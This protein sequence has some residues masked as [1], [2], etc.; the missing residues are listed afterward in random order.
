MFLTRLR[1]IWRISLFL[2][3][4]FVVLR[5]LFLIAFIPQFIS[6]PLPAIFQALFIG[7]RLD[8][9]LVVLIVLPFFLISSL[10]GLGF[11]P[12]RPKQTRF[13]RGYF[14]SIWMLMLFVYM[15][16]FGFYDYLLVR[17]DASMLAFAQSPITSLLMVWESYPLIAGMVFF[18]AVGYGSKRLFVRLMQPVTR[19]KHPGWLMRILYGFIAFI[20]MGALAYGSWSRYPLRWSDAFFSTHQP[21]NQLAIN[22]V[23]YFMNTYTRRTETYNLDKEKQAYPVIAEW[24]GIPDGNRTLLNYRRQ[25]QQQNS[26][27]RPYNVVVIFLETFPTFK[28]GVYGN[29]MNASPNFD[30]LSQEGLHFTN[31]YVPKLSTAAS[32]FSAMT[33][34]PDV[35][36]IDRSSTRDPFAI[37]QHLLMNDLTNYQKHFF[38]GGSANWGDVGG[39][40]RNNVTGIK[41]HQEGDFASEETNAW[42]IS[43]YDLMTA[44]NRVLKSEREP[45]F[46]VILTAGHHRPYTIPDAT[47]GFEL[48][49]FSEDYRQNG[50]NGEEEL[51]AFRYMDFAIGHL[52]DLAQKEDYFKNTIFVMFGDHGIGHILKPVPNGDLSLHFFHVPLLIYGPGAG[53]EP[54]QIDRVGS[55]IDLMPTILGLLGVP[56]TNTTLGRDFF[57]REQSAFPGAFT[58]SAN[59]TDYG[60]FVSP[61]YVICSPDSPEKL[62]L[63]GSDEPERD[64]KELYSEE[65][66]RLQ[67]LANGIMSTSQYLRYNNEP[68]KP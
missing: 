44:A 29:P 15:L 65:F 16:D 7:L 12:E 39:F 5:L 19:V 6:I 18:V 68:L 61:F 10:P 60:L 59:S 55:E 34:I 27:D 22:P 3:A 24:L 67:T 58:F 9:R 56:Y 31:F 62:Y 63:P 57:S 25:V 8:V 43:D 64:V 32:I 41:I 33:G 17:M 20:I 21:A 46:S 4:S 35:A 30:R 14:L 28:V 47:P 66:E 54:R 23:L 51:N 45:F 52:F 13:W 48:V 53:I 36:V 40:F 1:T 42:G 2:T 37:S 11:T 38:I 49:E 50:F 26:P